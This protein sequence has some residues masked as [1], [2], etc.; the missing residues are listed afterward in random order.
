M[1]LGFFLEFCVEKHIPDEFITDIIIKTL[2]YIKKCKNWKESRNILLTK[3]YLKEQ[4]LPA[5]PF[6]KGVGICLMN[7]EKYNNKMDSLLQLPQFEKMEKKR[8]N[9]KHPVLKEE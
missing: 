3:K 1:E 7:A 8:K 9:A 4:N 6:D 2:K 5:V